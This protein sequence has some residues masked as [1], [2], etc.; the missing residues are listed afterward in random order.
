LTPGTTLLIATTNTGKLREIQQ[1][2]AGLPLDVRALDAGDS[3]IEA[4]EETGATF[5]ENARLKALY[6]ARATGLLAA[7][8]DSGLEVA[9][10]GGRPGVLSARYPGNTYPERFQNLYRELAASGDA[11]RSARFVCFVTLASPEAGIVFEA[12]GTVEGLIAPEPC[13]AGGF[14][15][16]PIFFHPPSAATLAEIAADLKARISHRGA[17]FLQL[18][19]FLESAIRERA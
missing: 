3:S 13:G 7:A 5:A 16:D 17:A 6:Y 10:L 8:D 18:R 12:E 11:D 1:L 19:A 2:L 4:P 14:G 9:A 15:Y